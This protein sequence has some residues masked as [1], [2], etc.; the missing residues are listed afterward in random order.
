MLANIFA[1]WKTTLWV[2]IVPTL[3]GLQALGVDLHGIG[4][5]PLSDVWPVIFTQIGLGAL[6]KDANVAGV[7]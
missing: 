7:K 6:A 5:P 3:Y 1:S 2:L 4:L